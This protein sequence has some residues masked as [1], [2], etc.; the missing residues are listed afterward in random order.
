[1]QEAPCPPADRGSRAPRKGSRRAGRARPFGAQYSSST[2]GTASL[3]LGEP[4]GREF[5]QILHLGFHDKAGDPAVDEEIASLQESGHPQPLVIP[6]GGHG[7][8]VV[9]KD[10]DDLGLALLVQVCLILFFLGLALPDLLD[11]A[12]DGLLFLD[13]LGR[14]LPLFLLLL[15]VLLVFQ[16]EDPG[17]TALFPLE[18]EI[19]ALWRPNCSISSRPPI[20][21]V[22][23]A[24]K[25]KTARTPA[26]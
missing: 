2:T 13:V 20:L 5:A 14:V 11:L 6:E 22:R 19:T 16:D 1:V 4:A 9:E 24:S 3:R 23:E 10:L 12:L 8:S 21:P 26:R 18:A 17:L 7:V 25:A 15:L